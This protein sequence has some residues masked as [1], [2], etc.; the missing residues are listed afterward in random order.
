MKDFININSLKNDVENDGLSNKPLNE[1]FYFIPLLSVHDYLDHTDFFILIQ[2]KRM[3]KETIAVITAMLVTA[4]T[5]LIIMTE[6][7]ATPGTRSDQIGP[8]KGAGNTSGLKVRFYNDVIVIK[9]LDDIDIIVLNDKAA[10]SGVTT[11][12]VL[13]P[14]NQ[15]LEYEEIMY[16][17]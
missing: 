6:T 17:Q 9:E 14:V 10:M 2:S 7:T 13:Q 4:G 1:S 16:L 8:S 12:E 11:L 5:L 3:G 15:I